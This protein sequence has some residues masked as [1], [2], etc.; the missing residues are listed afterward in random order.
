MN[1]DNGGSWSPS[2]TDDAARIGRECRTGKSRAEMSREEGWPAG[3]HHVGWAVGGVGWEGVGQGDVA[4]RFGR[5]E[6]TGTIWAQIEANWE[7]EWGGQQG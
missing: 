4:V 3:I 1:T 5:R 2:R 6:E 7:E